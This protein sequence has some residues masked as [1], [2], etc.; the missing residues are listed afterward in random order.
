MINASEAIIYSGGASGTE[1]FFGMQAELYGLQEVNYTFEGHLSERNRG[2]RFLTNEELTM[3]DVSITYIEKIMDR[4]YSRAPLFRK[5]LQSICWQISSGQEIFVVG[6]IQEDNTVNGGT[7]WGAE[8][9]KI[10]NKPL[11]V[12]DQ[13]KKV[14]F[15]WNKENWLQVEDVKI[16]CPQFAAT[17]TRF[18]NDDGKK[19]ITDL[20][21]RSFSK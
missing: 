16:T 7:G 3:K 18:L 12:F 13:D 10:C 17:G 15:K 20:F 21:A 19:A 4:D 11:Y 14:W 6:I 2:M 8:Y 1:Q 5:V 9:A